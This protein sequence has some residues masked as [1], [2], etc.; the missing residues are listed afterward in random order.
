MRVSSNSLPFPTRRDSTRLCVY[1]SLMMEEARTQTFQSATSVS[2][3]CLL[4]YVAIATKHQ[5]CN[6]PPNPTHRRPQEFLLFKTQWHGSTATTAAVDK[7]RK[8]RSKSSEISPTS[9]NA[10][11]A[12]NKCCCP[13]PL[14]YFFVV[15]WL[16]DP[17]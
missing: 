15:R 13:P 2:L 9:I 6:L 16:I 4:C 5:T 3:Y 1:T 10:R 14:H 12:S 8:R 17:R 11:H 7:T